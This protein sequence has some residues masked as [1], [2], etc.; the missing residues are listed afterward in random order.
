MKAK[1]C[2]DQMVVEP[3]SQRDLDNMRL[4]LRLKAEQHPEILQALIDSGNELI[5]EDCSRR[6]H[7]SG[8]FWGAAVTGKTGHY[9]MGED[10]PLPKLEGENWLGKLWMELRNHVS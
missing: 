5:F 10:S 4:V 1:S 6:R 7:G 3:L 9:V 2:K 8:L